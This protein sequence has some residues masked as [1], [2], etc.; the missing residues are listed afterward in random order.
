MYQLA[1]Q[2]A[3]DQS[4]VELLPALITAFSAHGQVELVYLREMSPGRWEAWVSFTPSEEFSGTAAATVAGWATADFLSSIGGTGVVSAAQ[5]QAAQWQGILAAIAAPVLL[6]L[7]AP[8]VGKLTKKIGL[9][10]K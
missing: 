5:V 2:F 9:E 6:G 7:L 8:V 3:S 1:F 4:G 10:E